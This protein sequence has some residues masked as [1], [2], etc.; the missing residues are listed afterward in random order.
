M[1][2]EEID[3]IAKVYSEESILSEQF[4]RGKINGRLELLEELIAYNTNIKLR[5]EF[6]VEDDI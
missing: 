2:Q 1:E 4:E 3:K 6:K 5:P